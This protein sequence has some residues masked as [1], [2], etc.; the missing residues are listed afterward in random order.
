MVYTYT[1]ARNLFGKLV[2]DSSTGTLT[3]ADTLINTAYKEVLASMDWPF[4]ERGRTLSTTASTQFYNLPADYGKLIDVTVTVSSIVYRPEEAP[5]REFWDDVNMNTTVESNVPIW[6]FI[7][8]GQ[9]GFYPVP[10]SSSN[11]ITYNYRR[12]VRDLSVADYT[13]GTIVSIANGG[14]ALVGSGTSMW[15]AGMAGKY[16]RITTGAA[17]NLG[18]GLWYE[19]SSVG[20]TTTITLAKPYLGTAIA[21]GSATYTMGDMMIIPEE[22]QI[23]PLYRALSV[24]FRSVQPNADRATEYENLYQAQM[25]QF[26]EQ[27]GGKAE[28]PVVGDSD[29]PIINPQFFIQL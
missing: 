6:Y 23:L 25:R 29:T 17:A 11:T 2:N 15:T 7:F 12:I 19:V 5:S 13:S 10:S 8:N 26:K 20:S 9:L 4:L 3:L 21:A 22:F 18:D 14:T 27:Y 16:I 1:S 24:F 28:S